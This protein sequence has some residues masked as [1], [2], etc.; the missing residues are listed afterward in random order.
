[1]KQIAVKDF[2]YFL[3]HR[4]FIDENADPLFGKGLFALQDQKWKDM[5]STLSPAFTGSKMRLMFDLLTECGQTSTKSLK[6]EIEKTGENSYEMRELLSKFTVDMI[7][8]CAFGLSVDSFKNP[9]ND[10]QKIAQ[11]STNLTKSIIGLKFVAYQM[12][13]KFMSFFKI[14]LFPSYVK[15]FFTETIIDTMRIREEQGI[16]RHD[17]I[18]LL[19]QAKKGKLNLAKTADEKNDG[20]ATV[21]ESSVGKAKVGRVW[22]DMDLA[23][24]GK[25][26]AIN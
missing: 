2:E 12:I 18:N 3:N 25:L 1:M 10:F 14:Q 21:E 8:T 23:A 4:K 15:D 17:M 11:V 19:I 7:A 26:K 24:Q 13:P 5:R 6:E 16:V 20:F 22:D 9:E